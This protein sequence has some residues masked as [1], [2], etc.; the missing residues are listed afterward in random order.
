M[1][2]QGWDLRVRVRVA[3]QEGLQSKKQRTGVRVD[4]VS[5]LHASPAGSLHGFCS[6][7]LSALPRQLHQDASHGGQL[8]RAHHGHGAAAFGSAV[9]RTTLCVLPG[10]L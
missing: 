8:R 1:N 10:Q 6:H 3:I 7:I 5:I 4:S 9:W 2:S